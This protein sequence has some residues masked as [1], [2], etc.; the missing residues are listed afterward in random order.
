MNE[1]VKS[2]TAVRWSGWILSVLLV[3][4]MMISAVGKF[5]EFKGKAEMFAKLG[6]TAEVMM[7]IGVVEVAIALMFLIPRISFIAAIFLTAYLGGAI[8]THVR[9]N[10]PFIFP[11]IICILFWIALGMRDH[12]IFQLALGLPTSS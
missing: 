9:I 6:W 5:T 11:M 4:F 8:A 10:D 3:A 7:K 12:R 2:N 1:S